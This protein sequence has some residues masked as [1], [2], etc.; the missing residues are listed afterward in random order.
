L[1]ARARGAAADGPRRRESAVFYVL[2]L[3]TGFASFWFLVASLQTFTDAGAARPINV[4]CMIVTALLTVAF[5][6]AGRRWKV[7]LLLALAVGAG[8]LGL[9]PWGAPAATAAGERVVVSTN[10]ELSQVHPHGGPSAGAQPDTVVL[11][12][13][14]ASGR[15]IPNV[16]LDV[17]M[18]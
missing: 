14:D 17:Q 4:V 9:A 16:L 1:A 18:D 15:A 5:V 13:Q 7:L 2:A 3:V 10:P 8:A 11:E 12:V 6:W